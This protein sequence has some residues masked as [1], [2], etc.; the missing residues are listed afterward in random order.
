MA[1]E[2]KVIDEFILKSLE[3]KHTKTS[4]AYLSSSPAIVVIK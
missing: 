3:M 2:E 1:S 4:T